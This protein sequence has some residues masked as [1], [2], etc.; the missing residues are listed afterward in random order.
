MITPLLPLFFTANP[1]LKKAGL[2]DVDNG[3]G[4]EVP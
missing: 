1:P 4:V 3:N 2:V